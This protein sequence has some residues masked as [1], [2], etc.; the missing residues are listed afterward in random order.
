MNSEPLLI[1]LNKCLQYNANNY[2]F[3][4]FGLIKPKDCKSILIAY[5]YSNK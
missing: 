2:Y 3:I 5:K 1:K 4:L